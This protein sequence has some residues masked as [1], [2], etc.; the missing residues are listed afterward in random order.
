MRRSLLAT[1]STLALTAAGC[2]DETLSPRYEPP[3]AFVTN[4]RIVYTDGLHN[5]NTEMIALDDRIVL[6]FRGGETGQIGS[7]A[8]HINVYGSKDGG[9]TFEKQ[10]E[11][12]GGKLEGMR[13][14][15]DPKLVEMNGKLYLYAISRLPGGH[16][17]DIG[18]HAWTVRAES[19]DKGV[20]W[21]DPV[22]T[23]SDLDAMGNETFWGFW[24]FTKR[25]STDANGDAKQTLYALG[26]DDGDTQVGMFASDDGIH[27]E[28]RSVV[29]SSYDDV[30]SEAELQ[31]FGDH[32]ET[33]VAIVRMDNQGILQ[34]GQ[35]AI[36]TS[37]EPFTAWECSRRV[38]QRFDGP[39]W[40]SLTLGGARRNFMVARKHLPCTY[41][42]TAIYE[43]IGDLADP[44]SQIQVCEI[45]ELPSAGD[46]AYTAVVPLG[47]T[48][49]LT[50]WYSS[51]IPKRGD[52]A[53]LDGTFTPADIWL[54]DVDL[55]E[56]PTACH[57][58]PA[59]RVCGTAPLPG[60]QSGEEAGGDYLMSLAP[61]IYPSETLLFR[62]HLTF[63]DDSVD[64]KM[65]PL[66][67]VTGADVGDA[68]EA[69]GATI[70][71][72]GRFT[73]TFALQYLPLEAFPLLEDP[74]LSL[75]DVE[76]SGVVAS[77]ELFCGVVTG[78]AQVYGTSPSDRIDLAGTTF[79][80][81]R[82]HA[83]K[84]PEPVLACPA[85]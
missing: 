67:K 26:Y 28:K 50:S 37:H 72:A 7:D 77:D 18:G 70:D 48:K 21:T 60:G 16:Y 34:D 9:R 75:N 74:F 32:Q 25:T 79:G 83:G 51:T 10:S 55:A 58:P 29:V 35:S 41:K 30:P 69:T 54:A 62:T 19:S 52:I 31:F 5:E 82:I 76:L 43:L 78:F 56:A 49:F 59:K 71:A 45:E 17:R 63:H 57:A 6:I 68:W 85:R 15:R 4:E 46:T 47:G 36:C 1:L 14:I 73:A 33:A 12:S 61:V 27:W 38:E 44:A 8:A 42:R 22:K 66:D 53:W 39:T 24:R 13:D 80:A 11:V 65:Q 81:P 64:V 20:T 40:L 2:A 23:F 84:T 3:P